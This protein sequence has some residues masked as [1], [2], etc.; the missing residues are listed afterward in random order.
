MEYSNKLKS[1]QQKPQSITI[2]SI[3]EIDKVNLLKLIKSNIEA[4]ENKILRLL[5]ELLK[6]S[7]LSC[8]KKNSGQMKPAAQ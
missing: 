3:D 5:G 1:K 7:N 6:F 4:I 2:S 8:E